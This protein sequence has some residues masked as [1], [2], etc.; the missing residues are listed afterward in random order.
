VEGKVIGSGMGMMGLKVPGGVIYL[1]PPW[2]ETNDLRF[3]FK[4]CSSLDGDKCYMTIIGEVQPHKYAEGVP[5][6]THVDFII[7]GG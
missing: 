6:L 1:A 2:N 4:H 5:M 7:P 3:L